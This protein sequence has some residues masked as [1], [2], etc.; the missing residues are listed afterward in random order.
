ML[1]KTL[2]NQ[3]CYHQ[4]APLLKGNGFGFTLINSNSFNSI[5]FKNRIIDSFLQK[6][7]WYLVNP[8]SIKWDSG[9]N[10]LHFYSIVK[11]ILEWNR[12]T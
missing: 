6:W 10:K 9:G 5:E 11:K 8:N 3:S 4:M 1:S 2:D 12:H 7:Q